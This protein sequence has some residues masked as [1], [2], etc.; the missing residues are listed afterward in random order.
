MTNTALLPLLLKQLKLTTMLKSWED[1]AE[2][3]K[4]KNWGHGQYLQ[5]LA[6]LEANSRYSNKIRR[7][8]K[9]AQLPAGP[10]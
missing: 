4:Q 1:T 10:C 6:E 8:A 7:Y 9:E 2:E 3:A 5:S